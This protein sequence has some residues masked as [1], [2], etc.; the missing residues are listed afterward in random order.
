MNRIPPFLKRT[1]E[2]SVTPSAE[3]LK[4]RAFYENRMLVASIDDPRI[5]WQDR[6]LLAQIGKKLY[7]TRG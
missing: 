6:E 3:D 7:P 1:V 5:P 2:P 4:R